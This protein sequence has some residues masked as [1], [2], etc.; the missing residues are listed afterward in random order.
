MAEGENT[1]SP[2]VY[3]EYCKDNLQDNVF[4]WCNSGMMVM[5]AT[6]SSLVGSEVYSK[7]KHVLVTVIMGKKNL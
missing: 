5:G 6:N 1:S 3:S 2:V 4:Y 7:M